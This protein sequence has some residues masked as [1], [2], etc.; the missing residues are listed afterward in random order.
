MPGLRLFKSSYYSH[1]G[2][3]QPIGAGTIK[4]GSLKG[5]GSTTRMFNYCSQKSTN[6]SGCI[7]Q[8][9]T[10]KNGGSGSLP[11]QFLVNQ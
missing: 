8:F 7:N 10:V 3:N 5:I 1:I 4:I 2:A 9:I 11:A 6:P